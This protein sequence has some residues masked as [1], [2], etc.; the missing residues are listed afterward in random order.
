MFRLLHRKF[1]AIVSVAALVSIGLG[2]IG[3]RAKP[4]PVSAN[5]S[6]WGFA[7]ML[8]ANEG[9]LSV[10]M[11]VLVSPGAALCPEENVYTAQKLHHA[12]LLGAFLNHKRVS[13]TTQGC[14]GGIRIVRVAVRDD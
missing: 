13:L 10:T 3:S 6:P 8:T 12:L 7:T 11:D 5:N 9:V 1:Y 2:A 4:P 14:F